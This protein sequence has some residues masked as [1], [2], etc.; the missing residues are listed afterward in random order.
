MKRAFALAAPLLLSACLTA[1]SA[2]GEDA[3]QSQ[4]TGHLFRIFLTVTGIVYAIVIVL[5]IAA[6]VRRSGHAQDGLESPGDSREALL[7]PALVIWVGASALILGG[8]TLA[9]WFADR[10]LARPLAEKPLEIEVIGHQWWWEVRYGSDEASKIV[11]TAN[12]LH[13][14]LGH[15]AHIK[16]SSSDVI[17]SLWIPNLAGKQDLIPGR[18]AD[19][20]ILP[21]RAGSYR[22]QCA[23]FCGLQHANMAIDVTVESPADF[24]AW[25]A[26]SVL[27][28]AAPTSPLAFQGY[29]YVTAG[30]CAACHAIGGTPASGAVAPDLTHL[31]SR[32][33]IAAGT[34]PMN[35]SALAHWV[36]NPQGPKPGNNMPQIPMSDAQLRAVTAYLEGLK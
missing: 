16:L 2:A 30:P 22:G 18:K 19:L 36:K 33:S 11:R 14:P 7:R 17:H 21:T 5:L 13:L 31:A 26:R 8:L 12:E 24:A 27:P 35:P 9:S 34:L 23:E 29:Q 4:T 32:R 20:S 28:A 15:P 3:L 1:Q 25:R 6:L 10:A